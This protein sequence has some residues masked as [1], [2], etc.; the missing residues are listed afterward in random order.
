VLVA[1]GAGVV[2]G[3]A[4]A[5]MTAPASGRDTRAYL[6]QRGR[7][8]GHDAMSRGREAMRAQGARMSSAIEKGWGRASDALAHVRE[9]GE[10]AVAARFEHHG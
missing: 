8:L 7:E 9:Q 10:A 6:R 3:A 5:V 2:L 1:F 4:I